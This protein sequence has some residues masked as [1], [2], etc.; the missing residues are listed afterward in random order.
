M[1]VLWRGMVNDSAVR[2][3]FLA[4][5]LPNLETKP[6]NLLLKVTPRVLGSPFLPSAQ[7]AIGLHSRLTSCICDFDEGLIFRPQLCGG[8]LSKPAMVFHQIPRGSS[9]WNSNDYG[10]PEL[11]GTNI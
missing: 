10:R 9:Q 6:N 7:T 5:A 11:I 2:T 8:A 3:F 1:L 4:Q